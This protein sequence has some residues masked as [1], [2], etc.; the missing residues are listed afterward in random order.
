MRRMIG[1]DLGNYSVKMSIVERVNDYF[2][3]KRRKSYVVPKSDNFNYTKWLKSIITNFMQESNIKKAN[4]C[5][6]IA[7]QLPHSAARFFQLPNVGKKDLGKSIIYEIEEKVSI[8]DVQN[9][10]YK[11]NIL[12]QDEE[13][14]EIFLVIMDKKL[15]EDLKEIKSS[16]WKIKSIEP[17]I[18]SVGRLVSGNVGIIDLGHTGTRFIVYESGHPYYYKE[19][20]IG[21]KDF[22]QKIADF[23]SDFRFIEN[24]DERFKAAEKLK[25]E[26]GCILIE[27]EELETDPVAKELSFLMEDLA[28]NLA[29]EIKQVFQMFMQKEGY[30]FDK[31]Y[32][33]GGGANLRYLINF[34]ERELNFNI[35]PFA[36][37][38][39]NEID[40][41]A[42][43]SNEELGVNQ[44][45]QKEENGYC[46]AFACGAA[47]CDEFPY[48]KDLNFVQ[49]KSYVIAPKGLFAG[50]LAFSLVFNLGVWQANRIIDERIERVNEIIWQQESN[51]N[52]I[53]QQITVANNSIS[54]YMKLENLVNFILD[55][56][57]WL[58]NILYIL[59]SHINNGVT[60]RSMIVKNGYVVMQGYAKDYTQIGFFAISLEKIGR[61][62]IDRVENI[63]DEVI[64][65][66]KPGDLTKQF[67]ISF[68]PNDNVFSEFITEIQSQDKLKINENDEIIEEDNDTDKN[69][70]DNSSSYLDKQEG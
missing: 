40:M 3:I 32:F 38:D 10:F 65:L 8:E 54:E 20:N 31:L 18:V 14:S 35:E 55:Q 59:P 39:Y 1:I 66:E 63:T 43:D 51:L 62:K 22:T 48:M 68:Y 58:S 67:V 7:A 26:K 34:L 2:F 42:E 47:L 41:E 46:Y 57:K 52:S 45:E 21:G 11:W 9:V 27:H 44:D 4:L 24:E 17:Q 36:I 25:H 12:K 37:P 5:F 30:S 69:T 19:I 23:Y 28:R 56:K 50:V 70:L 13:N 53:N 60:I 6:N 64:Y 33:T 15:I 61:I 29:L 49:T 16:R